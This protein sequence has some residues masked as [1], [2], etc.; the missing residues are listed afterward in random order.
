MLLIGEFSSLNLLGSEKTEGAPSLKEPSLS[1]SCGEPSHR[2][3]SFW[4][5]ETKCHDKR[6]ILN[7]QV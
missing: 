2:R 7:S 6:V 5:K 4:K 3:S 1:R